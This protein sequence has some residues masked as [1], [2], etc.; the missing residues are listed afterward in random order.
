MAE[1]ETQKVR[2]DRSVAEDL[3]LLQ[4]DPQLSQALSC[5]AQPG[6]APASSSSGAAA[7]GA[8]A[9]A[10]PLPPAATA[11]TA[12]GLAQPMHLAAQA[13]SGA[14]GEGPA[15]AA[16]RQREAAAREAAAQWDAFARDASRTLQGGAPSPFESRPVPRS[17]TM[18]PRLLV[19]QPTDVGR[20][21]SSS[22]LPAPSNSAPSLPAGQPPAGGAAAAI[23]AAETPLRGPAAASSQPPSAGPSYGSFQ[24]G[25]LTSAAPLVDAPSGHAGAAVPSPVHGLLGLFRRSDASQRA[26]SASDDGAGSDLQDAPSSTGSSLAAVLQQLGL[27]EGGSGVAH[28]PAGAG[29]SVDRRLRHSSELE[30]FGSFKTAA[31]PPSEAS[32]S[33]WHSTAARELRRQSTGLSSTASSG[34]PGL[35]AGNAAPRAGSSAGPAAPARPASPALQRGLRLSSDEASQRA[36]SLQEQ[37]LVGFLASG[38]KDA[39][40]A[41]QRQQQQQSTQG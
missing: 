10:S 31:G 39:V 17:T 24:L 2:I 41:A 26:G 8:P 16:G 34:L 40:A 32:D 36:G 29:A 15:A 1:L 19:Q 5:Y 21:G 14:A 28:L 3:D 4:L 9:A 37:A 23:E 25:T 22:A 33:S 35:P 30:D 13:G 11:G 27:T 6:A 7:A 38:K 12:A 20:A 18:D